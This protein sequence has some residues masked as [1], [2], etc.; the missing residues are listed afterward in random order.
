M[1]SPLSLYFF[2]SIPNANYLDHPVQEK[3]LSPVLGQSYLLTI[4]DTKY[5]TSDRLY[6]SDNKSEI[7]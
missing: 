3:I 7:Y 4:R 5:I 6:V 2:V 1:P